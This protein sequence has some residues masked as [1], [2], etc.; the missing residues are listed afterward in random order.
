MK[1]NYQQL[2]SNPKGLMTWHTW[3]EICDICG[4]VIKKSGEYR[5]T[6]NPDFDEQDLCLKCLKKKYHEEE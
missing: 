1:T 6:E 2:D 4:H 3:T 5:T